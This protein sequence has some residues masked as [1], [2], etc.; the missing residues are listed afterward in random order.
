MAEGI[1]QFLQLAQL[2]QGITTGGPSGG[3]DEAA[4]QE[5]IKMLS[6]KASVDPGTFGKTIGEEFGGPSLIDK[7]N[8]T[9]LLPTP[10]SSLVAEQPKPPALP[11][12]TIEENP[13]DRRPDIGT[14]LAQVGK[15]I[16][17]SPVP[18]FTPPPALSVGT[19]P[20]VGQLAT[21]GGIDLQQ[22]IASI[23]GAAG[24]PQLP[25]SFGQQ[26]LGRTQGVA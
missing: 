7:I 11:P 1:E 26:L 18:K 3:V 4:L 25:V 13:Q 8:P 6:L 23:L 5:L 9:N 17:P 19:P 2:L 12:G 20:G 15:A 16:E 10:A 14:I 21:G 24:T 22:L